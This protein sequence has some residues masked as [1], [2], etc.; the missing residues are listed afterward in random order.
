MKNY[1]HGDLCLIGIKELPKELKATK[2]K[3]LMTGSGGNHHTIDK[4]I[5][6]FKQENEFVFGYL[7]AK[8][9]KLYHIEH[10]P[11]GAVIEDGIYQLRKQQEQ[12]HSGM[13]PVVD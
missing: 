7:V 11:K 6:Y 10:S 13:R 8:E 9:T 4:G 3:I 2:T 1:R 5:V 12:T